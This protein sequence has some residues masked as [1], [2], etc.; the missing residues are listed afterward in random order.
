MADTRKLTEESTK[1][2]AAANDGSVTPGSHPVP[3]TPPPPDTGNTE[4][5]A[6]GSHPVPGIDDEEDS[7]AAVAN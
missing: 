3:V 2:V 4:S 6:P 5:V 1:T 7:Q